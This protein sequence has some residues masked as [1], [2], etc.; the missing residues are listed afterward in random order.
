MWMISVI[1]HRVPWFST[2]QFLLSVVLI[3]TQ[4]EVSSDLLIRFRLPLDNCD[5]WCTTRD[6][7]CCAF[8]FGRYAKFIIW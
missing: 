1:S 8:G 4:T 6:Y 7:M 5:M 3:R 2:Y